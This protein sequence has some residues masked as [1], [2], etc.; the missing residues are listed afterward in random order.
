[1][2]CK[3]TQRATPEDSVHRDLK[4]EDSAPERERLFTPIQIVWLMDCLYEAIL[5]AERMAAL[6]LQRDLAMFATMYVL[7]L[8]STET[9]DLTVDSF[10]PN[11]AFPQL[12]DYGLATVINRE[13]SGSGPRIRTIAVDSSGLAH[14]L[15]WYAQDVRYSLLSGDNPDEKAFFLNQRGNPMAASALNNRF[16]H[17]LRLAHFENLGLTLHG[18]RHPMLTHKTGCS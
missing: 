10:S 14:T 13:F 12:G 6:P 15:R 17:A 2:L 8:R 18:L 16:R 9:I 1:M 7:G 5:T 3:L 4:R 11:P